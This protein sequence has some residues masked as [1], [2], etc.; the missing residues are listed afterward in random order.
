MPDG[1]KTLSPMDR[2][3]LRPRSAADHQS[4][5]DRSEDEDQCCRTDPAQPARDRQSDDG[6]GPGPRSWPQSHPPGADCPE[7]LGHL[8]PRGPGSRPGQHPAR[9]DL[10]VPPGVPPA[11]TGCSDLC[12]RPIRLG[13]GSV[14]PIKGH[15]SRFRGQLRTPSI[16]RLSDWPILFRSPTLPRSLPRATDRLPD[17]T[18]SATQDPVEIA[19]EKRRAAMSP[20][21]CNPGTAPVH[22]A[23]RCHERSSSGSARM[24]AG[25]GRRAAS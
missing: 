22:P 23:S 7:E 25:P 21:K 18:R 14:S 11:L 6:P 5:Q 3:G 19:E 17:W 8:S 2:L 16:P 12:H 13:G 15:L 10:G 1:T 9:V 24:D 20:P 4:A